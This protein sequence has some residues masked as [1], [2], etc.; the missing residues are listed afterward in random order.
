M[1]VATCISHGTNFVRVLGNIANNQ[2]I[3][4]VPYICEC[5]LQCAVQYSQQADLLCGTAVVILTGCLSE[6]RKPIA[7]FTLKAIFKCEVGLGLF[8]CQLV[9]K[10]VITMVTFTDIISAMSDILEVFNQIYSTK[11]PNE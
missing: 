2:Q 5:T 10:R 11:N 4:H 7:S 3:K 8:M 1:H 9:P 6:T